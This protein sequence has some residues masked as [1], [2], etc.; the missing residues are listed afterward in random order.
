LFSL[1]LPFFLLVLFFLSFVFSF[2]HVGLL[3]FGCAQL[4]RGTRRR[5]NRDKK[6]SHPG[7]SGSWMDQVN[8]V[9]K[10]VLNAQ[11]CTVFFH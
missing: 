4:A 2:A 6:K 8:Q 5:R 10:V 3:S 9:E 1:F 7:R 11:I